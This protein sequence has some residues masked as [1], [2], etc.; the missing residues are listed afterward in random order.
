MDPKNTMV[1]NWNLV[2]QGSNCGAMLVFR[3]VL[4]NSTSRDHPKWRKDTNY[5]Q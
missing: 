3:G 4:T 5:V 1:Y 2:F